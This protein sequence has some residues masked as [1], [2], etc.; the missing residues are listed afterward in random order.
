VDLAV[1]A[2]IALFF[3]VVASLTI[4]RDVV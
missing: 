3:G 4:R 2:A 1:L